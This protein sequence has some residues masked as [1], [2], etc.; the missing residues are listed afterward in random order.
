MKKF[1]V[2]LF[3]L[4]LFLTACAPPTPAVDQAQPSLII[5]QPT[6]GS[7]NM[8]PAQIAALTL[9]S[10]TLNLSADKITLVSTETV[11][12]PDGCLGVQRM[13]MMCTQALVDG[14]K[15]I[16]EAGGKEYELHTNQTGSSVVLVG[17]LDVND[18]VESA[19][20][21]QLS[22]NLGLDPSTISIVSNEPVEF[23]DACLGVAMQDMMCAEVITPGRIVVQEADG[24][25]YEY[26]ANEDASIIQP[27]T[28]AL[29]WSRDGGIAGF[30]DRLT[31]FLSGEVFGNQ[32]QSQPDGRMGTFATLLSTAEKD[33]FNAW[34]AKYGLVTLDESDPKGVADGM[35]NVVVLFGAGNGKPDKPVEGGI[36]TW[37]QD[38]FQKLYK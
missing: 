31:V 11:T 33:Q 6:Q 23:N 9:L 5:E 4:V 15:I 21:T 37:A 3:I 2:G 14:Y 30:C 35:S 20:I 26:H 13:G 17:G 38:V 1:T 16:F 22:K 12:W 29:T 34:I 28:L 18:T 25:Q 24:V 19:L 36:F 32:C 8:T 27:A 7:H 10:E